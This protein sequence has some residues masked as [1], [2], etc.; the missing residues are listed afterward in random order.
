MVA[1]RPL[2]MSLN[3]LG[4]ADIDKTAT[5]P[6]F[7][8]FGGGGCIDHTMGDCQYRSCFSC[9][10]FPPSIQ[11]SMLKNVWLS[12]HS[13]ICRVRWSVAC[14]LCGCD[15]TADTLPSRQ[16]RES[17]KILPALVVLVHENKR[18]GGWGNIQCLGT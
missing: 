10:A 17:V 12:A 15:E 2:Q 4:V 6:Q 16:R 8:G 14:R 9:S 18:V 11:V 13:C 3:P 1:I 7:G 5:L